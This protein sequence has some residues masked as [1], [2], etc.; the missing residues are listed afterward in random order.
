MVTKRAPRKP[1]G[2]RPASDD[3]DPREHLLDTATQ[4]FSRHGIAAT[5]VGQIASAAGV[6]SALVHYYF[7]NR[8][9]LL[10][11]VAEERLARAAAFVWSPAQDDAEADPFALVEQFVE[12]LL[13]VIERLPWLP[14][15]WLREVVGEGGLLRERMIQRL[16]FDTLH[17]F[18]ARVAQAQRDGTVSPQLDPMLLFNSILGLVMLPFATAAVWQGRGGLPALDRDTLR[19]HVIAL[20]TGGMRPRARPA[21]SRRRTPSRKKP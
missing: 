3:I 12:R 9:S 8:E 2:R 7:T 4:L 6:A 13:D 19:Q 17:R 10:D 14:A 1:L 5:T 16:P 15:L 21:A 18:G 11:A 20:L